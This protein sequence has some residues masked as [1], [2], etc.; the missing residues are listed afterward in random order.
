MIRH[1][2]IV[3]G[4]KGV[5]LGMPSARGDNPGQYIDIIFPIRQEIRAELTRLVIDEFRKK[6][7]NKIEGFEAHIPDNYVKFT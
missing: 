2:R 6:F 5:F 7:P 4:A 3:K 1:I